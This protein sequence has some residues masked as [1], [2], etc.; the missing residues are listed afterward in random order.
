MGYE[1]VFVA[2]F[3]S[4]EPEAP[5]HLF[6]NEGDGV[7]A[8]QTPSLLQ[9]KGASHGVRFADFDEDGDLDLA[10]ANNAEVGGHWL[11][12]NE[13]A[14]PLRLRALRVR[15]LD[16]RGTLAPPGTEVRA[17]AESGELLATRMTDT[18]GGYCSQGR[19]PLFF[20]FGPGHDSVRLEVAVPAGNRR[21]IWDGGTHAVGRAETLE[22]LQP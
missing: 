18:G 3:L 11:Y 8:D 21:V 14:A 6:V 22:I 17:Y 1:D 13:L 10:L 5:D 4:G 9:T 7:F 2:A 15:V 20:A 16:D 12:R 19:A